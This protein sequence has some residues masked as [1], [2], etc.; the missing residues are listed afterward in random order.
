VHTLNEKQFTQPTTKKDN[1]VVNEGLVIGCLYKDPEAYIEHGTMIKSKY[2]FS[3]E[4]T[5]FLFDSF[6]N[7]YKS[8]SQE[9]SESQV[10]TFMVKD[11]DR[12]AKYKKYGGWK[13]IQRLIDLCNIDDFQNY[14]D[15]L[16]KYSL[17][18]ELG[19]LGFP[20]QRILEHPKFDQIKA[21]Q[22]TMSMRTA[23]D[24][25][26]TIIG[27]G[28]DSV[29]LGNN[30]TGAV[31]KWREIPDMGIE[32]P[33]KMWTQLLKGWRK[34]K[35]IVDG[36][37]SNEGK[38]RRMIYIVA[39][40]SLI[41]G[42][43]VLV[44]ANEMDEEDLKASLITTVCNNHEFG[45]GY[46]IPERNIT[47]GEYSSEEEYLKVLEVAEYIEKNSQI[48]YKDMDDYSD[49][50]IEHEVRK[51]VLGRGVEYIVYDTLKAF[52]TDN[53]ETLKQTTTKL[54]D[55]CKALNVGG[56]ANIQ[57]TDDSLFVDVFDFSSNNIANAKQLKHVVDG[58]WLSRKIPHEDY[59]N[60]RYIDD[61]SQEM[62]LNKKK[63]IYGSKL[64]KNRAGA[65][66]LVLFYEVDLDLNTWVEIGVGIRIS[67]NK[68]YQ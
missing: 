30:M 3:D 52:R 37:L 23:L 18:R 31:K 7:Y 68:K 48:I 53:W 13:T 16:K 27:G 50:S 41:L 45:F 25:T 5:K 9:I 8:F 1:D 14:Y 32:F 47:L 62:E 29:I 33:F 64:D 38:S 46:N 58:L 2:D 28:E 4:L 60:Y 44:M 36:M 63:V 22:V 43:K 49:K 59:D 56:Y 39:F 66:G 42:K 6:E 54:R 61:W 65:K 35:L 57:L 10:N 40:V 21:E 20:T 51:H 26:H 11:D 24:K 12:K 15:T 55:L 19:R 34:K 67:K 17:I